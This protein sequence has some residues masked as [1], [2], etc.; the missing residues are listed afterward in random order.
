MIMT[1]EKREDLVSEELRAVEREVDA[2]HLANPLI[3][4]PFARA[5]WYFL[6]FCEELFIRE[7]V[8]QRL[9]TAHEIAAFADNVVVHTKWPIRWLRQACSQGG[10]IPRGFDDD[11]YEAAWRLSELSMKYLDFEAAFTYATSG[12]VSLVLDGNRIKSSGPMRTDGR[13]DAYDRFT[14]DFGIATAEQVDSS[15]TERVAASVRVRESSF[16][17]DLNPQIVKA[18]LEAM[19]PII[20]DRFSLP[21]DWALPRY[22]LREFAQVARV[23]WIVAFIHFQARVV[24]ALSGCK[25][26]GY[27][28]A[29]VLMESGELVRRIRRYSGVREEAVRA[30]IGDLTYGSRE[31]AN[32]DPALQP[33]VPLSPSTLAISPSLILNSSMERNLA[34]LLNRLPEERRAYSA[35]SQERETAMRERLIKELSNSRVRFWNGKIR[36]WGAASDID[37]AIIS[38]KEKQCLIL[39]LKSF[40]APAEPREIMD[41]SDEIAHGIRQIRDRMD[42]ER[43]LPG[44]LNRLLGIDASYRIAW[45]VAS[46]TSV[47]AS[48]VQGPDVPVVNLRHLIAKLHRSPHLTQCCLWLQTQEHLPVEGVH[49]KE[50]QTEAT[51][52]RWTL[53]WYGTQALT[54]DYISVV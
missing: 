11:M 50:I 36:E 16:E 51:I 24:A 34:V 45:A 1:Q 49:Y 54:E 48:Y 38:D 29:L 26:L 42:R 37:L 22:T 7:I 15:F 21:G 9:D 3:Q 39:E 8:Q 32:P 43:S 46:E 14:Q 19:S 41:R 18:G 12:L 17:Y 40:I 25:A 10:A 13:F 52:G 2:Y 4:Q 33:I 44:P 31:Q 35:L 23:L 6:A 30:I 47:G 5:G 20:N 53:E 27:A 28:R